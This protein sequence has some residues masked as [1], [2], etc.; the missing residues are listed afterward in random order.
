MYTSEYEL[1]FGTLAKQYALKELP[2]GN[3]VIYHFPPSWENG[4]IVQMNPAKGL[5]ATS[6]WFTPEN[7]IVYKINIDKPCMWILCIDCGEI[8]YTQK[9]KEAKRL[10]PFNHIIINPQTNFKITFPKGVH[11]CFTCVLIFNEYIENYLL[12]KKDVPKIKVSDAKLWK[13]QHYNTPNI[14]LILEQIRWNVRNADIHMITYECKAIELLLAIERNYPDIPLRRKSRKNYV[15]WENEQKVYRVKYALD[16]DILNPINMDQMCQ[17][18]EMSESM[19][20]QS[21][22]NL[23]GVPIYEYIRIETMKRA[24]QLLS[25]DHL[26]IQNI[27]V[28]CGYKNPGKF[29]AAFKEI[30]G[31]TPSQFRKSFNL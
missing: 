17:L 19:L 11:T 23:Y 12:N 21:F 25:A 14:M 1:G 5:F 24:M 22:K 26:S 8:I 15:T 20:R 16:S 18:S 2:Y 30:H 9:G 27:A 31:I 28:Q 6:A 10:T 4:W 13:V 3:G 29:T 7:E